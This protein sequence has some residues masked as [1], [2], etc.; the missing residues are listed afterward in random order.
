MSEHCGCFEL[1]QASSGEIIG[2]NDSACLYPAALE[3]IRRLREEVRKILITPGRQGIYKIAEAILKE[4]EQYEV[5][6]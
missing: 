3:A 5:K 1:K 4:T 6:R 2:V